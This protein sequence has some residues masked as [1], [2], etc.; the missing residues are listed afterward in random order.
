VFSLRFFD[1]CGR[2]EGF[3]GFA[4]FSKRIG[5]CSSDRRTLSRFVLSGEVS[6]SI[7]NQLLNV[8]RLGGNL[9]IVLSDLNGSAERIGKTSRLTCAI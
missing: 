5:N 7:G 9:S 1:F 8:G 6:D 3:G 2:N 4:S